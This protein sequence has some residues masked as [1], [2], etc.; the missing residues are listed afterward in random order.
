[1]INVR[2]A[3]PPVLA[4]NLLGLAG[5]LGFVVAIGAL[6]DWR[7][8]LL[9]GSLIALAGAVLAQIGQQQAA[10]EPTAAAPAT[11]PVVLAA[12]PALKRVS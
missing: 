11:A 10:A 6:T 4:S 7:W 12:P 5:V 9:V 1:M 2:I 3:L 8:A